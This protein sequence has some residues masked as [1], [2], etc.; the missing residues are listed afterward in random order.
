MHTNRMILILLATVFLTACGPDTPPNETATESEAPVAETEQKSQQVEADNWKRV[1][2][3]AAITH[4]HG[5]GFWQD[6][7]RPVVATHHGL[8]EYREDGWYELMSNRHDYMG[9]ELVVDGFYASGHPERQSAFK[10]PLGVVRGTDRGETLEV[11]SLEGEADFHHMSVGYRSESLYVYLEE[12]TNEL[13]PGFYRS[14]DKGETIEPMKMEGTERHGIVGL[15]ADAR[16]PLRVHVYGPNGMLVSD[17]GG[18]TFDTLISGERI[19]LAATDDTTLAYVR[20]ASDY[21]LVLRQDEDETVLPLP[22]LEADAVPIELA[23][24]EGRL[25]LATS[26]NSVYLYEE[27]SWTTLLQTGTAK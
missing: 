13:R 2:T 27:G 9:F 26:D 6:D 22:D 7:A 12:P 1:E 15:L 23:I 14:L 25:L 19:L 5:A 18:D 17:D 10:N 24:D 21:E 8:M 3:D 20:E 11:R 4:I 16:E